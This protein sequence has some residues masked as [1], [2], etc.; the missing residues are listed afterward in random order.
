MIVQPMGKTTVGVT[1]P[2]GVTYRIAGVTVPMARGKAG[3]A[4]IERASSLAE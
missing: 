1:V 4:W 3:R 2:D